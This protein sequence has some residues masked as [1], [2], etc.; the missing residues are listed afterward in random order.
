MS[1]K[2]KAKLKKQKKQEN[3]EMLRERQATIKRG[4]EERGVNVFSDDPEFEAIIREAEKAI[5][6]GIL[7]ER[8]PQGSSGSYFVLDRN[9]ACYLSI[10]LFI[11]T[12]ITGRRV[13]LLS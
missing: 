5:D 13:V 12:F 8:I 11:Y 10:Y 1:K 4:F 7:P 6:Q 3:K 2:E 9:K